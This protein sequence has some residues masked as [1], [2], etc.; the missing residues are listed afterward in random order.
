M[1]RCKG[2]F[3]SFRTDLPF[4][5]G[6]GTFCAARVALNLLLLQGWFLLHIWFP[7]LAQEWKGLNLTPRYRRHTKPL[8]RRSSL[9]HSFRRKGKTTLTTLMKSKGER[10]QAELAKENFLDSASPTFP[11]TQQKDICLKLWPLVVF[12]ISCI[13]SAQCRH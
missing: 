3:I 5:L 13:R 9:N 6:T 4:V 10:T 7:V 2:L 12:I 8:I 11:H 1:S